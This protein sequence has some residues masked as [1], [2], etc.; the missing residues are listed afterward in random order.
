MRWRLDH[1]VVSAENLVAGRAWAE[2][3]LG[4][5]MQQGGEHDL[6]GTHNL[7][8]GLGDLYLEVIAINPDAPNPQ[9]PRW[10]DLD[11]FSGPPRMTH[12][13]VSCDDLTRA[14]QEFDADCG[15]ITNF[16]RGDLR[17]RVALSATG[18]TAFDDA[19]PLMIEWQGAVRVPPRL[20]DQGARLNGLNIK[21]PEAL[22][23][24]RAMGDIRQVEF[25][26]A[27]TKSL[28]ARF[29]TLSGPKVLG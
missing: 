25:T 5:P 21:S 22:D 29:D 8:L 6:M 28:T 20:T 14:A 18:R 15:V 13:A 19:A 16:T 24:A 12:W 2:A 23:L 10:F 1:L 17:W 4:V 3:A 26:K 9:R 27:D 11:N 7:L